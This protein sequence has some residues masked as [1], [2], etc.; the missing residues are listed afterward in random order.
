MNTLAHVVLYSLHRFDTDPDW[1]A[2]DADPD[3][4]PQHWSNS[5]VIYCLDQFRVVSK[6]AY[7]VDYAMSHCPEG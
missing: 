7:D 6:F 1:Y 2:L 4:H 5:N 3:F